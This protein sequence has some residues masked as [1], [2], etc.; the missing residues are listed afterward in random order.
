[1]FCLWLN[2]GL[3]VL[4]V[5][6]SLLCLQVDPSWIQPPVLVGLDGTVQPLAFTFAS[7]LPKKGTQAIVEPRTPWIGRKNPWRK[8]PQWAWTRSSSRA[9]IDSISHRFY[10]GSMMY[11]QM[12]KWCGLVPS[13]THGSGF[14]SRLRVVVPKGCGLVPSL[15]HSRG[16]E[17]CLCGSN[18]ACV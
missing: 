12:A 9:F 17:S 18:P 15:P 13:L 4:F 3:M 6:G 11:S 7:G 1:M 8:G 16:L 5:N 10:W 14:K 2:D